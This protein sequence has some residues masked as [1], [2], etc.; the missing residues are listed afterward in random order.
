MY[1]RVTAFKSDPAKLEQAVAFLKDEVFPGMR[2]APGFVG[3]TCVVDREKSTGAASTL[4]ESLEAMNNAEQ[5]GQQ[6]RADSKQATG[7]EVLDVDRFE[8]TA[9]EMSSGAAQLPSYTRIT[10]AYGDPSKLDKVVETIRKEVIPHSKGQPGFRA[11]AAGVNRM[12]GRGFTTSSWATPEQRE[13]SNTALASLRER[14]TQTGN[15]Y[16]QQVSLVETVIAEIKVP[17]TV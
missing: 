7:L 13:A 5:I 8:I 4:W 16:G 12:T 15:L 10:L 17:T 3:A 11:F 6:A 14:A 2:K 1:L 9:L